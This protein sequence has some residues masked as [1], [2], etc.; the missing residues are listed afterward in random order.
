M[1]EHL[2]PTPEPVPFPTQ[3]GPRMVG[4]LPEPNGRHRPL[5]QPLPPAP[6][7]VV[8]E[9]PGI[10]NDDAAEAVSRL[11]MLKLGAKA[12]LFDTAEFF[13]QIIGEYQSRYQQETG[14]PL[15]FRDAV[16]QVFVTISLITD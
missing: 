6:E 13:A 12:G 2:D 3:T 14:I 5:P 10:S 11:Q 4:A 7:T 8:A 16:N 15:S 9:P 1:S